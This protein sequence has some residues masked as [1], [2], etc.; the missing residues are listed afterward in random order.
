MQHR[1]ALPNN[2][3]THSY[4]FE[5]QLFIPFF[6]PLIHS[7]VKLSGN[8]SK[9][10]SFLVN[11]QGTIYHQSNTHKPPNIGKMKENENGTKNARI[12]TKPGSCRIWPTWSQSIDS[13]LRVLNN[14]CIYFFGVNACILFLHGIQHYRSPFHHRFIVDEFSKC[15]VSGRMHLGE[16]WSIWTISGDIGSAFFFNSQSV[17][18]LAA[19][20]SFHKCI[21]LW[22]GINKYISCR[23]SISIIQP[24]CPGM[25]VGCIEEW[26]KERRN[27][28]IKEYRNLLRSFMNQTNKSIVFVENV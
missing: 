3:W 19:L 1:L 26:W 8:L 4:L 10:V 16:L 25:G 15:D 12:L 13:K 6:S 2:N 22:T 9:R 23:G 20:G 14:S 17:S 27:R 24:G 7:L 18:M 28:N 11:F 21:P 5:I